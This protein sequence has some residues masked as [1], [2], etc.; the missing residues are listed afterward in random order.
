[1][2]E[3]QKLLMKLRNRF[4]S[5]EGLD[6]LLK[7]SENWD[8]Y[9]RE[10]AVRRLGVLGNPIAIPKLILRAND[11][12]PQVRL[13]A[14]QAIHRLAIPA[15][16]SAFVSCLPEIYHLGRCGR[17]NHDKLIA[18]IEGFLVSDEN[19]SHV[20]EGL[21]SD[22]PL[23][24]RASVSLILENGLLGKTQ[25]VEMLMDHPDVLVRVKV[26]NLLRGL[27][28]EVRTPALKKAIVDPFMPIRREAF[29]ILIKDGLSDDLMESFLFDRHSSIREIAIKN[30]KESGVDIKQIYLDGLAS[31][32]I[33]NMRCSLW[34]I[35]ELNC[36]ED[37]AKVKRFLSSAY[38]SLRKQ[39]LMTLAKLT[40]SAV[41]EDLESALLD[42]SP[43]VCKVSVKL[44]NK[45][46]VSYS[47]AGLME[48]AEHLVHGHTLSCCLAVAK[49]MNK[50]ER[51]IFLVCLFDV[52]QQSE[53][54]SAT[55]ILA[56]I[57]LWDEGFNKSAAQPTKEQLD[58]LSE[59]LKICGDALV[60][61]RYGNIKFTLRSFG[62]GI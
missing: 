15:N 36:V 10:N 9:R 51:L 2:K 43:A 61:C 34:G 14:V 17:D 39:S 12:V 19:A 5:Q 8:G 28:A 16:A 60:S 24:A 53:T 7:M 18:S 47:S 32:T 20:I 3:K 26:C 23:V 11:W 1:M 44:L 52:L 31:D 59:K 33:F 4:S 58:V 48:I 35:G 21:S 38:P 29:Q 45:L 37:A 54:V 56:A 30:L 41:I 13:A 46:D 50:W 40:G 6:D 62:V 27:D 25:V 55:T 49:K 22:E 42:G 57:R